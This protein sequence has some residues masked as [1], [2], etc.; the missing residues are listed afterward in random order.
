MTAD[1][2]P[3]LRA[4][5]ERLAAA[6]GTSSPLPVLL[7]LHPEAPPAAVLTALQRAGATGVRVLALAAAVAA[8][9]PAGAVTTLAAHPDVRRVHLDRPARVTT[10]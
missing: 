7:A 4:E 6:G 3:A 1:V 5:L 2:D 9:L 10:D 8:Q